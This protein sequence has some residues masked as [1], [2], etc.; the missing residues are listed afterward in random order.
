MAMNAQKS[1]QEGTKVLT[2]RDEGTNVLWMHECLDFTARKSE[3]KCAKVLWSHE[4]L[5][6]RAQTSDDEGK[7]VWW[8]NEILNMNLRKSGKRMNFR[9]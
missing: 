6:M 7:K 2:C 1:G 5:N 4:S 3:H 9:N 8:T